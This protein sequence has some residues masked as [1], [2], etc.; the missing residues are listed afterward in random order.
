[1]TISRR[2]FVSSGAVACGGVALFPSFVFGANGSGNVF[3]SASGEFTVHPVRHASFVMQTP[4]GTIYCDPVG[5]L[6]LYAEFPE[7]DLILIT[8]H[9]GDHF[10]IDTLNDIVNDET[11]MLVNPTVFSKLPENLASIS[12]SI[13]N[14]EKATVAGVSVEAIPAYNFTPERQKFHPQGRDNSY[15]LSFD[16]FRIFVS[17]DTEDVP[18]MRAL[19]DIDLAFLC[20]NLPFTMDVKAAASAVAEFRPK[21]VYPYHYRGRDEGTQDPEEFAAL[22]GSQADIRIADWY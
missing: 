10:K 9:H 20:M 7:P 6:T 11:K 16:D 19:K 3:S 18:E 2:K 1:M 12:S 21:V 15:V 14:G 5:D 17:G 13:G 22:V 8:H 4:S